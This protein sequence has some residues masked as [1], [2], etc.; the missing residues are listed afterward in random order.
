M[1][2]KYCC[3]SC[4]GLLCFWIMSEI[5]SGNTHLDGKGDAFWIKLFEE[6]AR[7]RHNINDAFWHPRQFRDRNGAPFSSVGVPLTCLNK[8]FKVASGWVAARINTK[9][10]GNDNLLSLIQAAVGI[11][12]QKTIAQDYPVIAKAIQTAAPE[13]WERFQQGQRR[14]EH[15]ARQQEQI[16]R[17]I[18][19]WSQVYQSSRGSQASS[20]S[21]VWQGGAASSGQWWQTGG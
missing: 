12:R 8:P 11:S 10:T 3:P 13:D 20:S 16:K 6:V 9:M 2:C 4:V 15:L 1:N 17:Q 21:S 19:S 5:I 7:L 14:S 18:S